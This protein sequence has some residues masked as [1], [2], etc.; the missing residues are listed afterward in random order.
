[1]ER[2][3]YHPSPGLSWKF[4]YV[5]DRQNDANTYWDETTGLTAQDT[6]ASPGNEDELYKSVFDH[7]C[8]PTPSPYVPVL[9][10]Q[11]VDIE[12]LKE[13]VGKEI[14]VLEIDVENK[15]PEAHIYPVRDLLVARKGEWAEDPREKWW[16]KTYLILH[17][18]PREA[19][20]VYTPKELFEKGDF[21]L[22][23]ELLS[24]LSDVQNLKTLARG[25]RRHTMNL[26]D[27]H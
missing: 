15:M 12:D 18:V 23:S 14:L 16:M 27:H 3:R 1:M 17:R 13:Q 19:I 21:R 26:S 25:F 11:H 5:V 22:Y 10:R 2:H 20:T 9:H 8:L 7:F 6:S 4:Y 24:M